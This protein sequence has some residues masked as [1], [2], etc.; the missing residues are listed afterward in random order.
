[1]NGSIIRCRPARVGGA[2]GDLDVSHLYRLALEGA[3]AGTRWH[4]AG[5]DGIPVR[6]IAQ[7]IGDCFTTG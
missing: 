4:A 2:E 6:D 5:D 7:S 1:V 3:P